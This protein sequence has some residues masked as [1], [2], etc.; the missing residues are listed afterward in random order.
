[1]LH[2][3]DLNK[4]KIEGLTKYKD[5]CIESTL[6]TGDKVLSFVYPSKAAKDIKEECYIRN[7]AHQFVVK[8]VND[9]GDWTS[10][11]AVLN[12]E[13]L[14][15]KE[16]EHFSTVE[17]TIENCFN[18]A[19]AGTG[20]TV[21]VNGV[22]K[23]R[24]I[25]K[26]NCST[27]DII[28][29][30]KKTYLVEIEFD[31]INKIVKVYEKIGTDKGVYFMDSLNLRSLEVQSNSYDFYT[32]M[33]AKGKDDLKVTV[34][35]YKY[36]SKKKTLIW[37]DERYTVLESLKEDATAKLEELSKPRRAYSANI[38][39]LANMSDRYSILAY[40]LGDIVTLISKDKGI[41]EKQR[42]V[43]IVEYP[44]EPERNTAEIANTILR[45]EDMQKEFQDTADTVSNITE[46]NGTI[47]E[48][49]IR[50]AVEHITI[51]KADIQSL[52]AVAARIG[53]LEATKADIQS[54]N[55]QVARID[56]LQANKANIVDLTA[57][58][59][60]ISTLEGKAASIET[61]LSKEVFVELA[62]AG[63]IVAGS[64]IIAEGAIGSAQISSLSAVKIDSGTVDTSKVTIQGSKG[65]LKIAGDRLQVFD[66]TSNLY[67]R[68]CLGDIN[69]DGS[70]YGVRVRGSDG[71]TVLL[72]QNGVTKEGFTD[73]YN[74]LN[75]N[76]LPANKLDIASVVTE[77]NNGD[78]HIM[79]SKVLLNDKTL[80]VEI[81]DIKIN[82][83][84]KVEIIS[85]NG[86]VINN[87]EY[88]TLLMARVYH[89]IDDITD[90]IDA[91][92]FR[93]TR[94]SD[95]KDSDVAWNAAHFSGSKEI[96]VSKSD[97]SRRA[98][99]QCVILDQDLT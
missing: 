70:T 25:R 21:Q 59:A 87:T 76:S 71:S 51:N 35:N 45:F 77:I 94:I 68:V 64:S 30:A 28:Q 98:T 17:Q 26:T 6:S 43:K 23:K 91:N 99:F 53:T 55:A 89:G 48:G 29:Q 22:T 36:S 90:T 13:E 67:E 79:G 52:N 2:L 74:K 37:K 96:L 65:R 84:Y 9:Q 80:D 34:E 27:W 3:Y 42:I 93:W 11:K 39:D 47:S 24:T 57:A 20:W 85:T 75:D 33:I 38:I 44:E 81:N 14:E 31:S 40:G 46:D 69:G 15:G 60:K 66:G 12:V 49:A 1:M 4:N 82:V 19:L 56:N 72:D 92:R 95:D 61:I 83:N 8:E 62:S 58:N 88:T 41:K 7:K 10:I 50:T 86:N 54:L 5:Y 32:R 18:L 78:T 16:W 97:I 73:G 63:K